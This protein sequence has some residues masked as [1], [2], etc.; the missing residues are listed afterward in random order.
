[1]T[2]LLVI[3]S[4]ASLLLAV[5]SPPDSVTFG[6]AAVT[7]AVFARMHQANDRHKELLQAMEKLQPQ[8][9]EPVTGEQLELHAD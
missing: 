3:F 5:I 8:E 1:M 2:T 7:F 9:L 6:A 4:L